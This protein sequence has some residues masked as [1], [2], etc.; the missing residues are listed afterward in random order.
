MIPSASLETFKFFAAEALEGRGTEN[1]EIQLP[2]LAV[3]WNIRYLPL[4]DSFGVIIGASF[5]AIDIIVRKKAEAVLVENENR[6]NLVTKAT[7]DAIWDWDIEKNKFYRGEGFQTLFG[8]ET[9]TFNNNASI[10]DNLIH[11]DDYEKISTKFQN[12]LTSDQPNWME[13]YRYLKSDGN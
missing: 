13:E 2:G 7:F 5:T 11:Q 6:Y 1:R 9:G 3:W 12:I 4:Y 8:Q 10:W